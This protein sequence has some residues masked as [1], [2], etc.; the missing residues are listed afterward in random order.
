MPE[1]NH[2]QRGTLTQY[3]VLTLTSHEGTHGI[4]CLGIHVGGKVLFSEALW[5]SDFLD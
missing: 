1:D 2:N 4:I 5:I 3:M